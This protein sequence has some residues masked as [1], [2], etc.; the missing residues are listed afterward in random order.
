M[1]IIGFI[2]D[3]ITINNIEKGG[4]VNLSFT[5]QENKVEHPGLMLTVMLFGSFV[6]VISVSILMPTIPVI[7]KEFGINAAEGQ[8]LSSIFTIA[9][10]IMVPLAAFFVTR[11]SLRQNFIV[12]EFLFAIGSLLGVFAP[13]YQLL[14]IS[15][16]I[17]GLSS[18]CLMPIIQIV[19]ARMYLKKK[20]GFVMG[21]I[22]VVIAAGPAIGS[23]LAGVIVN[24]LDWHV[25]FMLLAILAA[26]DCVFCVVFVENIG[27]RKDVRFDMISVSCTSIGIALLIY[28][29]NQMSKYAFLSIPVLVPLAVT[30]LSFAVFTFR[31]THMEVP[32]L[33]VEAF[34]TRKY[35]I[36]L[37]VSITTASSQLAGNFIIPLSVQDIY[38]GTVFD[39][40]LALLPGAVLMVL[41]SP[42]AGK[43]YDRFGLKKLGIFGFACLTAGS[44]GLM[45]IP[46]ET[47]VAYIALMQSV[48]SVGLGVVTMP[49]TTWAL[50]SLPRELND[51]GNVL[52]HVT[53]MISCALGP[54]LSATII[55]RVSNAMAGNLSSENAYLAGIN[56]ACGVTGAMTFVSMCVMIFYVKEEQI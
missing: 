6:S 21:I 42:T 3:Y 10:A 56:A 22:G 2:G 7:M 34:R 43:L 50:G 55:T 14:L 47:A 31:Q 45:N 11:F 39:S 23:P 17:Q 18:G 40:A 44:I 15:R 37:L 48:R 27:Q 30:I 33:S 8:W 46:A 35:V 16:I 19:A 38:G 41:A 28:G 51:S 5:D 52:F 53:R 20:L 4:T 12:S 1:T 29:I 25:I 24:Y 54:A 9:N 26:L 13:N 32:F 36:A 49:V